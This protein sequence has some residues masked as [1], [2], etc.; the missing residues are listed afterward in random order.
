MLPSTT[1]WWSRSPR[2]R[3][4]TSRRRTASSRAATRR[5][6]WQLQLQRLD[7][8]GAAGHRVLADQE[9]AGVQRHHR[10]ARRGGDP[11]AQR[12]GVGHAR[13]SARARPTTIKLE[14]GVFTQGRSPFRYLRPLRAHLFLSANADDVREALA[15]GLPGGARADRVGAGRRQLPERSAHRLR[16]RRGAVLRRGRAGVPGQGLDA[17]QRARDRARRAAAA[18]RAVQAAAGGAAPAAA[19]AA[20]PAMS[21]RTALVTARSAPAH[22]RAIRT[23]MHWNIHVDEAMFLGGLPKGEFLREFEP[24][25]F[26]DD[27]TRP[28][29]PRGAARA[30][31]ARRG[32]HHQHLSAPAGGRPLGWPVSLTGGSMTL[33]H[34]LAA[35]AGTI[36]RIWALSRTL[37]RLGREVEGA[38]AARRD[39]RAEP[40]RGVPAGADQRMEPA[41]LR[42]P[43]GARCRGVLAAALALHAA[44]LRRSSWSRSTGST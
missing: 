4:S 36:R 12:P 2:A 37:L 8:A 19:G 14:R 34:R 28:R 39:R 30:G 1:S 17:F 15:A 23:L 24:D 32:R 7:A 35:S 43:A 44:R 10:A 3:C 5:P 16:R 40:R 9:A 27:Q 29:G 25:F 33:S 21:I 13:S 6:T 22:E 20:T 38:R 18:R 11:L 41:L 31:R 42:R 26:F